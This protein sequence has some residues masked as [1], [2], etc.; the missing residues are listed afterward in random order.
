MGVGFDISYA[1]DTTQYL[2]PLC[3]AYRIGS[4]IFFQ[5]HVCLHATMLPTMMIMD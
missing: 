4:Q 3:V 1:Q 5:H 2:S